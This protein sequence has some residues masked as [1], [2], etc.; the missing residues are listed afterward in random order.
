M[1]TRA[2]ITALFLVLLVSVAVFGCGKGGGRDEI[3]ASRTVTQEPAPP[4]PPASPQQRPEAPAPDPHAGMAMPAPDP[5]A[6]ATSP[7]GPSFA[8]TAP[9]GW[10]EGPAKPMRLVTFNIDADTECYVT[11]LQGTGG[12]VEMN[13]NRW[14]KQMGREPLSPDLVAALPK[15]PVGDAEGVLVEA[16]GS[17]QGMSGDAKAGYKLLGAIAERD[18][19]GIFVKMTGPEATVTAQRDAFLAFC[20]SIR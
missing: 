3:A 14:L 2:A 5:H 6:G 8:W 15:V 13:A 12:G 19:V 20:A 17:Y 7:H 18:G 9:E 11:L 16:T 4:A 10:T 1:A